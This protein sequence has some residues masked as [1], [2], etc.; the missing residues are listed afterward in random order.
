MKRFALCMV[1]LA[2]LLNV[3]ATVALADDPYY[4]YVLFEDGTAQLTRIKRGAPI[5]P[6]QIEGH[7]LTSIGDWAL[8]D[9]GFANVVIPDSVTHLG[10]FILGRN[11]K[12]DSLVFPNTITRMDGPVFAP[13]GFGT[14]HTL[15]V[16]E[17]DNPYLALIDGA[18]FS[19]PDKRLIC[20]PQGGKNSWGDVVERYDVPEGIQI[21]GPYAFG[22][23]KIG[24]VT[25]PHTVT[26]I[27]EYA[28][29][30]SAIEYAQI[31]ANIT[32]I[33][34]HCFENARRLVE[35]TIPDTVASIGNYAFKGCEQLLEFTGHPGLTSIGDGAFMDCLRL[36]GITLPEGLT[37]LGVEAFNGVAIGR[38]HI[39]SSLQELDGNPFRELA[40]NLF[41]EPYYT[42]E[43][44]EDN[45]RFKTI[46]GV[47]IDKQDERIVCYPYKAVQSYVVPDEIVAIGDCAF[48]GSYNRTL[49]IH[50]GVTY[51]ADDA[52]IGCKSD[53]TLVVDLGSYAEA[54]AKEHNMLYTYEANDASW[55]MDE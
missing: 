15:L 47:L 4:E 36:W 11:E 42:I 45:P 23:A 3:C 20:V 10:A 52:F 49:R 54:Y 24:L 9:V 32:F 28:F 46:D 26:E 12:V 37:H 48:A 6:H 21:I 33:S 13:T 38:I 44:S 34:D 53:L 40:N 14:K 39:P 50:S 8:E 17:P 35:F 22:A 55:L 5:I 29:A 16:V 41:T 43:V 19:K 51:I 18:L 2:L 25:V 27:R 31:D 1:A 30:S 7:L